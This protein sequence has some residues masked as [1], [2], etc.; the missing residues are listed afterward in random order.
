MKNKDIEALIAK[1]ALTTCEIDYLILKI[2]Q[3]YWPA[4]KNNNIP[5]HCG[6]CQLSRFC[7]SINPGLI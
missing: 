7:N 1:E 3:D 2:K 6:L 5:Q 4:L